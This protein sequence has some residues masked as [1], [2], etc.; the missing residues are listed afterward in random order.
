MNNITSKL[1]YLD[2]YFLYF[3]I[4]ATSIT[5]LSLAFYFLLLALRTFC[6][7]NIR[8]KLY[9]IFFVMEYIFYALVPFG[10]AMIL[11]ASSIF[12]Y[13]NVWIVFTSILLI[14][15]LF[16]CH[17]MR[18]RR[19][20]RKIEDDL[21]KSSSDEEK[22]D[23]FTNPNEDF[24]QEALLFGKKKENRFKTCFKPIRK[25]PKDLFL[26]IKNKII[27]FFLGIV[28][29]ASLASVL[30]FMTSSCCVNIRPVEISTAFTRRLGQ[31]R[32]CGAHSICHLYF[33]GTKGR[34]YFFHFRYV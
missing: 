1:T 23:Q 10:L 3:E 6:I 4:T 26:G 31:Y 12:D 30:T 32:V 2:Y 19:V 18:R 15:S 14:W 28:V 5:I 13:V 33:T 21:A 34:F 9:Y 16:F 17:C 8:T 24:S 25:Y 20:L 27:V 22:Y 7:K 29:I 11:L